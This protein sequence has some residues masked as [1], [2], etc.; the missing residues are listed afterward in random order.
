[1]KLWNDTLEL[2][3]PYFLL[4]LA[5][6]PLLYIW[7]RK[8]RH[9]ERPDM[10]Y[11]GTALLQGLRTWKN[12][13]HAVLPW[14]LMLSF[15]LAVVALARPRSV[16][17][18][19]HVSK[20][21][22]IDIILAV[23]VSGSMLARD[24]KPNRLEALKKTAIDFVRHRPNDRIGLVLYAGE[25]FT[26]VP[27]TTDKDM[28]IRAIKDIDFFK[29]FRQIDQGTAIGMGLA[30]A[31]SRLKDSKAKSK[32]IIL[33]T[34]GVNNTGAIDPGTALEL[35][36]QFG[37]KVYT[38]GI[39]TN[40]IAPFPVFYQNGQIGYEPQK[41][42]IDE[43]LLKKIARETGGKYYRAT[44]NKKL[45]EIYREIDKMEKTVIHETRY[46]NYTE[47]YRPF[48]L[49]SL[50]LLLLVWLARQIMLRQVF[51]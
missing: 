7:F 15:A 3:H 1:M 12:T 49:A 50:V 26:K 31:V 25:A 47:L 27:L 36:K 13:L 34:D 24:F 8:T 14:L 11:S 2:T 30:T 46:Y 39:G 22:G 45:Q 35:A 51:I 32:V 43:D 44:S 42:E 40:G 21:K 28:L 19:K 9:R 10:L 33:M 5:V 16:G 29:L 41:V 37:I 4:L 20:T 23:D 48:L 6:I 17:V 18:S 38:I